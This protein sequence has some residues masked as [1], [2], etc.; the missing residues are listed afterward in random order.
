MSFYDLTI[1]LIAAF[2]SS[3]VLVR[4]LAPILIP[5]LHKLKFGQM[6]RKEGPQSHQIKTG[7][8]TMGGIIIVFAILIAAF[9]F[10]KMDIS[11]LLLSI[12]FMGHF[13]LGFLD[14]YIKVVLKRNLG[15]RAK[16][17][18]LGQLIISIVFTYLGIHFNVLD[19]FIILPLLNIYLDLGIL[20]YFLVI[21]VILATTNAV[22][23]TDGLDG[24]ASG[25]FFIVSMAYV[26]IG[27]LLLKYNITIFA[28]CSM[29]ACLGFLKFNYHPAKIFMGDTG[30]LALG[31]LLAGFSILT[32]TEFLLIILGGLFVIE[33]L[34]VIIQV[35][36]FKLRGKRVFLMSPIHH[37]FELKGMTEQQVVWSFWFFELICVILGLYLFCKFLEL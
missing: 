37:H 13:I 26:V 23:L 14:D 35:T 31:G 11:F 10:G 7:T 16:E 15:L 12:V 20:Y 21:C 25:A 24:L 30:S 8:P 29:A 17:K 5:K 3:Y 1:N 36:S 28:L 4:I 22:N 18:L 2:I 27:L 6:I 34:S 19:T 9:F 33:T 32:G